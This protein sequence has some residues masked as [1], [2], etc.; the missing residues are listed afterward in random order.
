MHPKCVHIYRTGC[1]AVPINGAEEHKLPRECFENPLYCTS[2]TTRTLL[3]SRVGEFLWI[4]FEL[5]YPRIQQSH[6]LIAT[7]FKVHRRSYEVYPEAEYVEGGR[8]DGRNR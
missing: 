8:K 7:H 5:S 4:E 6:I 3:C 1:F 2:A